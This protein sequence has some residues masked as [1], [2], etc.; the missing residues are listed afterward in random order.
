MNPASNQSEHARR[1]RSTHGSSRVRLARRVVD[2]VDFVDFVEGFWAA[3]GKVIAGSVLYLV[4]SVVCGYGFF[5]VLIAAGEAASEAAGFGLGFDRGLG[6]DLGVGFV[7]FCGVIKLA[8]V[9]IR[10]AR[11]RCDREYSVDQ[12][13]SAR[14]VLR[15][16]AGLLRGEA[17]AEWLEESEVWLLDL[18]EA[19]EPWY[20][21]LAEQLSLLTRLPWLVMI[22]WL[23]ARRAVDR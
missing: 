9:V 13:G 19:G 3:A 5:F 7:G 11:N 6:V 12:R 18:R 2:F 1:P 17:R 23:S 16:A 22:H 15:V 8:D 20:R 10:Y 21:L 14:P 4:G